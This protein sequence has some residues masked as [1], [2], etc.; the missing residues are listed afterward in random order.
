MT[1]LQEALRGVECVRKWRAE[2]A[3]AMQSIQ[4]NEGVVNQCHQRLTSM[5]KQHLAR[6]EIVEC[7][8]E[9]AGEALAVLQVNEKAMLQRL[10]CLEAELLTAQKDLDAMAVR[11]ID[12][13]GKVVTVEMDV[14]GQMLFPVA[15]G[16]PEIQDGS[17]EG[18]V[19][20]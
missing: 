6:I 2:L 3:N 19:G 10:D 1:A 18:G 14:P 7:A 17:D 12:L 4:S 13:V 15:D 9:L 8:D 11:L 20:C 5:E 16:S